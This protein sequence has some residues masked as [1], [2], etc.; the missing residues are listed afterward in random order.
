LTFRPV[1]RTTT[2]FISS[3]TDDSEIGGNFAHVEGLENPKAIAH[4]KMLRQ[5]LANGQ[6]LAFNA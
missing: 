4:D 1:I 2:A 5:F 3:N 6:T